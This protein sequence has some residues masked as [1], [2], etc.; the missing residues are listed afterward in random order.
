MSKGQW[1]VTGLLIA[2][3]ALEIVVHPSFKAAISNI[4][5]GAQTVAAPP[6]NSADVKDQSPYLGTPPPGS[7]MP[8]AAPTAVPQKGH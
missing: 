5:K 7:P 1:T 3:A 6:T 8:V 4:L 2:L